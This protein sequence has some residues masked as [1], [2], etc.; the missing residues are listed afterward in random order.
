MIRYFGIECKLRI[1]RGHHCLLYHSYSII[2]PPPN[3]ILIIKA[4]IVEDVGLLGIA[5]FWA[6]KY[7][8]N[9]L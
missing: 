6:S 1:Q 7:L 5:M 3:P 4:S 2:Y 9:V 8:K